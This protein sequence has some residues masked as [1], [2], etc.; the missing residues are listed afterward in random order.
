M[1]RKTVPFEELRLLTLHFDGEMEPRDL[2]GKS[3]FKGK[4]FYAEPG[5]VVYSKIDVRN[6]A[7]GVVPPTMP[8]VAVS[9]EYPVYRVRPQIAL[10]EYIKLLFRTSAF[11]K[12]INSM[13]SGASGRKRVQPPDLEDILVP[14]PPLAVQRDIVN[15]WRKSQ[16]AVEAARAKAAT[17][18]SAAL[19]DFCASL[20]LRPPPQGPIPKAFAVWWRNFSR[21]S[22]SHSQALLSMVDLSKGKHEVVPLGELVQR[23][24]YGT[25]VKANTLGKGAAIIRMNNVKDGWLDLRDIKHVELTD[26]ERERLLLREGDI[27]FNR[28]NSKELVGKCA[29]FHD[30][31]DFVFASYLIRV[32]ARP[33]RADPDYLAYFL[34][35]PLGRQQI[36]ALSRHIIGQ[37]NIN[38]LELRSLKICLPP[39][40]AQDKIV[41]S[42]KARRL[43]M[44]RTKKA[45]R[46]QEE[47]G[48]LE[49]EAMIL[50]GKAQTV[51]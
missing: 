44:E 1:N 15:R 37:A 36:N 27:L 32:C 18:E 16:G 26:G 24:Q 25:S 33:E 39:L 7:I 31:G 34:N 21:W 48:R 40:A 5:D 43:E 8:G 29:V 42:L 47:R 10:P 6:G 30:S 2:Q 20:G 3:S 28:T 41:E 11:R 45:T 35:S 19:Q 4:L 22:V 17:V 12:Q 38:S 23:V 14:L 13:V 46:E 51:S 50:G 49:V 9:S